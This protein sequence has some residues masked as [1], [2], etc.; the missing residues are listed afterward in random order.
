MREPVQLDAADFFDF[1]GVP[2]PSVVFLSVH[3]AHAFN[4]AL[5]RRFVGAT[6]VEVPFA[7]MAMTDVLLAD[8]P[9]L[10]FL[11]QGLSSCGIVSPLA[12]LPGYYLFRDGRMLAWE[13]GLPSPADTSTI[14]RGSLLGAVA[15]A[16]TREFTLVGKAVRFAADEAA[17]ERLSSR[18]RAACEG[19]RERHDAPPAQDDVAWAYETLGVTRDAT[20]REVNTAWRR[21]GRECH[22]DRAGADPEEAA[23]RGRRLADLHRA[24][25]IIRAHRTRQAA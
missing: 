9:V 17:A 13:S 5:P 8:V 24:R 22:P 6:D 18:F 12:M 1:V 7:V 25:E 23:R 14:L 11:Y 3:P 10:P 4:R 20:D 21:L 19:H 16:F 15:F 2:Q